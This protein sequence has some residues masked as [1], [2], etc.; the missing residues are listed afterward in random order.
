MAVPMRGEK[1]ANAGPTPG[2]VATGSGV[3]MAYGGSLYR[4]DTLS[5]PRAVGAFPVCN[6]GIERVDETFFC[7]TIGGVFAVSNR[8]TVVIPVHQAHHRI[9]V[10]PS[11]RGIAFANADVLGLIAPAPQ[12]VVR[13]RCVGQAG[14][15]VFSHGVFWAADANALVVAGRGRRETCV[16]HA[17]P[18]EYRDAA[19]LTPFGGDAVLAVYT[20]AKTVFVVRDDGSETEIR[21]PFAATG[22][23]AWDRRRNVAWVMVTIRGDQEPA[24]YGICRLDRQGR[25]AMLSVRLSNG[26]WAMVDAKGRLWVSGGYYHSFAVVTIGDRL[27]P[28]SP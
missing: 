13:Q 10:G 3:F 16:H 14:S 19:S 1:L 20:G 15:I 4:V 9:I 24:L 23:V 6:G 27:S 21:L 7:G 8:G 25:V 18:R 28:P 12:V 22:S 11:S 17:I 26:G 5:E 2:A